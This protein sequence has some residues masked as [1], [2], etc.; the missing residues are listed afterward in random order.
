MILCVCSFCFGG[1]WGWGPPLC[2]LGIS[3]SLGIPEITIAHLFLFSVND[4]NNDNDNNN[5]NNNNDNNNSN[6]NTMMMLLIPRIRFGSRCWEEGIG[7]CGRLVGVLAQSAPRRLV[8]VLSPVNPRGYIKAVCG[9][10]WR[11][12][13]MKKQKKKCA[14]TSEKPTRQ[15]QRALFSTDTRRQLLV[16]ILFYWR[17]SLIAK[18][19]CGVPARW[20]MRSSCFHYDTAPAMGRHAFQQSRATCSHD[21]ITWSNKYVQWRKNG[22]GVC[23]VTLDLP[24]R[25]T[26]GVS[27]S[28][29]LLRQVVPGMGYC[30]LYLCALNCFSH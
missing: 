24:C 22:V 15:S 8:G 3:D 11:E 17:R 2:F 7:D 14:N 16:D 21:C 10:R 28:E 9:S 18:D 12:E 25:N 23:R 1:L 13:K 29:S 27:L 19:G 20:L 30:C 6:N 5:N 4:V 26:E